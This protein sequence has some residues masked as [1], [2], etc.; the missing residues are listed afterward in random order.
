M[1]NISIIA[2]KISL[3]L[4]NVV[5]RKQNIHYHNTPWRETNYYQHL[6]FNTFHDYTKLTKFN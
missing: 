4:F 3:L 5:K 2:L 1:N 6:N